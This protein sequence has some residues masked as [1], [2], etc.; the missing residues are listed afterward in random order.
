MVVSEIELKFVVPNARAFHD[1]VLASGFLLK[2]PR[3]MERNSLFDTEQRSLRGKKQV[4]RLRQYGSIWTL[5]HK[6]PTDALAEQESLRYKFRRETETAIED[7]EAMG[8][9]FIE[10]GYRPVFRYEKYRTEFVD[11]NGGGAVVLDETPIGVFAEAEGEPEWIERTVERLGVPA[12]ACFTES[13]GKMFEDW[14]RRT[15]SRAL[16]MTFDEVQ[17]DVEKAATVS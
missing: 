15:G 7:G 5:T 10:L 3:T 16:N 17:A 6:R 14:Q 12:E 13:Y 1:R 2:T 9:V 11:A 8:A 4:L